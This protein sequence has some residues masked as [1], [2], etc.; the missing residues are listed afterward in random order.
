[1]VDP[2]V[3]AQA[4]LGRGLERG[5]ARLGDA[6]LNRAK[7]DLDKARILHGLSRE[8]ELD[9]L[10][11]P[12]LKLEAEK[13]RNELERLNA[14]INLGDLAFGIYGKNPS[15][16]TLMHTVANNHISDILKTTGARINDKGQII[17]A[18]GTVATGR[19]IPRFSGVLNLMMADESDPGHALNQRIR[20]IEENYLPN[21][22]NARQ[23]A[24]YDQAKKLKDDPNWLIGKY[25][26]QNQKADRAKALL[27]AS[28]VRDFSVIDRNI[29]RRNKKIESLRSQISEKSK[30]EFEMEKLKYAR[31]TKLAAAKITSK[32]GQKKATKLEDE[33]RF[34][35]SV[36]EGMT[37]TEATDIIRADR[38]M[39]DRL[40]AA[41]NE[42]EKLDPLDYD[43]NEEFQAAIKQVRKTYGLDQAKL[44]GLPKEKGQQT[45]QDP[46]NIRD[47]LFE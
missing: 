5:L 38:T 16:E 4:E 3:Y 14:P 11:R 1:M 39:S 47:L 19:D 15:R 31:D 29:A 6:P 28:G 2:V 25:E 20:Q 34:L 23:K 40:R 21:G 22:L 37:L 8:N 10:Q 41:A 33:A 30:R 18:D 44:R 24:W 13:A 43:T 45:I 27:S 7:F 32:T 42:I 35:K 9:A 26:Q 36:N 12:G 17:K 46:D